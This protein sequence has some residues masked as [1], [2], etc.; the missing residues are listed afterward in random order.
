MN[1]LPHVHGHENKIIFSQIDSF[2]IL[3][4]IFFWVFRI[5]RPKCREQH[6]DL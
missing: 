1:L 3:F 2:Y 5:E 6:E 4:S